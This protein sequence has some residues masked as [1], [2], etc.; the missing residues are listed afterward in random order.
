MKEENILQIFQETREEP[1]IDSK[2]KP[3]TDIHHEEESDIRAEDDA[4]HGYLILDEFCI[5]R[6][7]E[8]QARAID[9]CILH[10]SKEDITYIF[11][12][13]NGS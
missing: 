13:A 4:D 2:N 3:S 5:L 8:G 1:S 12:M 9:G 7:P 11:A 6:D 10:V